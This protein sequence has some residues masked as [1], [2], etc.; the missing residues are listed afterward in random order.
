MVEYH[1]QDIAT[2]YAQNGDSVEVKYTYVILFVGTFD[3][4]LW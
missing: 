1:G 2:E 3:L 4:L